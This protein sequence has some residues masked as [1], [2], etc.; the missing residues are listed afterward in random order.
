MAAGY[1]RVRKIEKTKLGAQDSGTDDEGG[2]SSS[3]P[4][5]SEAQQEGIT[6]ND[7]QIGA[8]I[9]EPQTQNTVIINVENNLNEEG[10]ALAVKEGNNSLDS[11]NIVEVQN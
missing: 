1:A 5:S 3:I 10:L 6:I 11:R 8:D 2:S 4:S 9:E 7:A